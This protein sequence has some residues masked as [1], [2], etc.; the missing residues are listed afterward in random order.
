MARTDRLM[1]LMDAMRRHG[2][3]VTAA[4]LAEETG[5]SARQLYRDIASLRAGGALIDG[6]AGVGYRLTEDPALPPQSFDR[7]EIEALRLAVAQ[8]PRLGDPA[9]TRAGEDALA[10]I[11][12]TLP[13]SNRLRVML[14]EHG[15]RVFI[16][17]GNHDA[18]SQVTNELT[19]PPSPCPDF[20]LPA[21]PPARRACST[22]AGVVM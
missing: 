6:A 11:I 8:L 5:V 15:I 4:R 13:T 10:R 2:G 14:D 12:A 7:L 1:R 21:A 22:F 17:R 20:T 19:L 3:P 9:L 16:I 18:Q